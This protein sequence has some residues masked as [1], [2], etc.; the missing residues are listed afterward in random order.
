MK[1][2]TFFALSFISFHTFAGTVL[3]C[4]NSANNSLYEIQLDNKNWN[5][6][7]TPIVMD[8]SSL[9]LSEAKL[10]YNEGESS[11]EKTMYEGQNVNGIQ[12]AFELSRA[13]ETIISKEPILA[14]VYF[15][16]GNPARLDGRATLICTLR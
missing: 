13:R 16:E 2:I 12:I 7:L 4:K 6:K 14:E 15:T 1:L 11:T 10:K 8:E 3:D 5:L 9:S